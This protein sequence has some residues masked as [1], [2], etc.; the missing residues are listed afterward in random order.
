M[1]SSDSKT[2][3][4]NK[5]RKHGCTRHT[6]IND[7]I[8]KNKQSGISNQSW[9]NDQTRI[10]YQTGLLVTQLA[11]YPT[12][13]LSD[14]SAIRQTRYSAIWLS[15]RPAIQPTDIRPTRKS[16]RLAAWLSDRPA[17]HRLA[18]ALRPTT[19]NDQTWINDQTISI[20][21]AAPDVQ[22]I[23]ISNNLKHGLTS[24]PNRSQRTRKQTLFPN[25]LVGGGAGGRT[26]FPNFLVAGGTNEARR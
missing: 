6:G 23:S 17:T 19:M 18:P 15:D 7:P 10:N 26:S 14:R 5:I 8:E 22:T 2:K 16:D 20:N 12:D 13:Q 9:I 25:F 4:Q 24:F 11:S 3:L 21:T 1:K